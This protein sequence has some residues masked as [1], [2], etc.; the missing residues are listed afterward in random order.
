MQQHRLRGRGCQNL[1]R[2]QAGAVHI[3]SVRK[4]N[5]FLHKLSHIRTHTDIHIDTLHTDTH[6]H[7]TKIMQKIADI[8][9]K[10][11]RSRTGSAVGTSKS[12]R[13]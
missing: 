5:I 12:A 7:T 11:A 4:K 6:T 8:A 13:R 3:Q 1:L 10:F 9:E 2:L